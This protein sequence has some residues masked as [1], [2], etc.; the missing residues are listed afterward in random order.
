MIDF[1]KLKK[2]LTGAVTITQ[3][4]FSEGYALIL[5]PQGTL[6]ARVQEVTTLTILIRV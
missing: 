6:L 5:E 2:M 4:P 1:S 3:L